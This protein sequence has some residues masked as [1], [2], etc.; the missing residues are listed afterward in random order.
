MYS[1]D[2]QGMGQIHKCPASPSRDSDALIALDPQVT[3]V[4]KVPSP[5]VE[6]ALQLEVTMANRP[7]Q[8]RPPPF[9]WNVGM[10]MHLLKG[11]PTLHDL[12][13]IQV[14]RPGNAY[15]FFYD[16]QG[17]KG[18]VLEGT[19]TLRAHVGDA[20]SEWISRSAHFVVN[21]ILLEEGW[22]CAM[23]VAEQQWQH[24]QMEFQSPVAPSPAV[25]KSDSNHQ[26][27]GNALQ[28][29]GRSGSADE[30][31]NMQGART[32]STK[33]RGR[34]PKKQPMGGGGSSPP[35]SPDHGGADSNGF[36]TTNEAVGGLWRHRRWRNEK[37][38]APACL[39]M[40]IFKTID[41]NADVMYTIWKFDV[42]GWLKQY[43]KASMMHIY[44][45]LQG[46]PGKWVHSLEECQ[47]ISTRDLLRRMD[48]AFGSVQDYDSMIRSLYEIHQK[49]TE[50]VEKYMLRIHK[51]VAILRRAHPEHMSDQGKNLRWD[52]FYHGLLPHLCNAL[53]FAMADLPEREQTDT[54]FDTLY[55]LA[56][57][58]EA[59]QPSCIQRTA[60]L[61]ADAY[62]ERYR[63][64]PMPAGRVAMLEDEDLFPPDPEVLEGES[65]N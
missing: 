19:H 35:S 8:L 37:C 44:H 33:Q 22:C 24:T 5:K 49:E 6:Y 26:L 51:A 15:L 57:K 25:S 12:E 64:Y 1:P 11:D 32:V 27:L 13:H 58:M 50:S 9:L 20:F 14:D 41:P 62:K 39:D 48:T 46:Y 53:G 59:N 4:T 61:P 21:P 30:L 3:K 45:S 17:R 28:P 54:S 16:K 47:N 40:P 43:D 60:A 7:G 18:L 34:P 55:T 52:R 56:R 65:L 10:L 36:S 31:M 38:L 42:E 23:A 63:R 2:E 29:T